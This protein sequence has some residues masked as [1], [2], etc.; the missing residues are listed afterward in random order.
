MSAKWIRRLGLLVCLGAAAVILP[1]CFVVHNWGDGTRN[2]TIPPAISDQMI[3]DCTS[4]K[5]TG[6]PR[7]FC[8]L[9]DVHALCLAKP[10]KGVSPSDCNHI[11]SYGDWQDMEHAIV[12]VTGPNEDCLSFFWKNGTYPDDFWGSVFKGFAGCQ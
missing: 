4:Q 6:A 2:I 5:G 8:V 3:W 1:G 11:S 9:D 7:A 10:D 12:E